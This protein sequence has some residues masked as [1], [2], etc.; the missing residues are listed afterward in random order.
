MTSRFFRAAA[1][2][3]CV[4]MPLAHADAM[5]VQPVVI[6]LETAGRGMSQVVT[7]ENTFATPL[8]VELTVQQLELTD[9]GVKL[10]GVDPGDLLVFP[11][12]ALIQPGQTQAFRVQYVGDP[13]LSTSKHYYITVAQLPVK[14]PEGQSAIQILYNFQVLVSV[15]PQ[16]MKA[17]LAVT[18]STVDT[19]NAGHREPLVTVHNNSAKYGYLSQGRLRV[20]AK[21]AAGKEVLRETMT[22]P[23]IQQR[24]GFGLVGGNQSRKVRLPVELPAEAGTVEVTFAPGD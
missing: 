8:P 21:D 6:D 12:Q 5:T 17:D 18:G 7:V 14:L 19:A 23:E 16:G 15:G 4:A 10:T 2:M 1:A 20:V 9:D 11:P 3:A 24:M 13:D 22:G